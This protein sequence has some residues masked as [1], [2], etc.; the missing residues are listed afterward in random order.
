[1]IKKKLSRIFLNIAFPLGII[2]LAFS[3]ISFCYLSTWKLDR[4]TQQLLASTE[5]MAVQ[6]DNVNWPACQASYDQLADDWQQVQ[7]TW[8]LLTDH[9][10]LDL[11]SENLIK[12]RQA[13]LNQEPQETRLELDLL[14]HFLQ[15]IPEK[16]RLNLKN[17]F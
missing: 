3:L 9:Q 11:V 8:A 5:Q 10:E 12:L 7:N 16:E 6:L 2:C 4:D 15:H 14:N 13:I 1:M 17:F